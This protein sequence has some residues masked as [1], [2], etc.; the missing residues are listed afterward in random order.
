MFHSIEELLNESELNNG[1]VFLFIF[2]IADGEDDDGEEFD[3]E[4]DEESENGDASLADG[5]NYLFSLQSSGR[6]LFFAI[7]NFIEK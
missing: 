5:K 7:L 2:I 6:W 1:I 4:E 3:E